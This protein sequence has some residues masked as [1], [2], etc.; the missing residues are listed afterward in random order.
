MVQA[1]D[2]LEIQYTYH[3][4]EGSEGT[5]ENGCYTTPVYHSHMT[6]CYTTC[7][8]TA[9]VHNGTVTDCARWQVTCNICGTTGY[10]WDPN[11][12]Y[13]PSNEPCTYT[14]LICGKTTSTIE[15]YVLGCGKTTDT[16]ESATIIY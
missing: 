7:P 2:T 8:G 12:N 10:R 4:H 15:E 13:V 1:L 3:V 14:Y 5:N 6:S 16:I 9:I 11:K